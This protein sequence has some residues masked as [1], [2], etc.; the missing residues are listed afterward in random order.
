MLVA[1]L[2]QIE[3]HQSQTIFEYFQAVSEYD[4]VGVVA[5]ETRSRSQVDN[6]GGQG[7]QFRKNVDVSHHVVPGQFFFF[8]SLLEVHVV[9]VRL[10]LFDLVLDD[11]QT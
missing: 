3:N 9:Y 8:G 7:A 1:K 2:R 4:K 10:H 5:H 11:V 6:G